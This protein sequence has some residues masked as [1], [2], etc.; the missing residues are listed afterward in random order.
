M[1]KANNKNGFVK[2]TFTSL[3]RELQKKWPLQNNLQW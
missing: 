1:A 3:Q 2:A